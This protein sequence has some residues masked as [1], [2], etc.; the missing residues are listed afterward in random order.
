STQAIG[1][2]H[3]AKMFPAPSMNL[4]FSLQIE[5]NIKWDTGIENLARSVGW[6]RTAK[7][8][9]FPSLAPS[10]SEFI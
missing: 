9:Y 6:F 8:F 10:W 5:Y 3:P 7:Y 4:V 1:A 2:I